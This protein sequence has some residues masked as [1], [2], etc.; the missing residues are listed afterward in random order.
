MNIIITGSVGGCNVNPAITLG[1]L[2]KER[3]EKIKKTVFFL[4]IVLS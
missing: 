2:I 3:D 4:M 1:I